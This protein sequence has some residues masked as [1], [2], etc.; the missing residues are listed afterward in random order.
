MSKQPSTR[1]AS[2]TLRLLVAGAV[3]CALGSL[4]TADAQAKGSAKLDRTMQPLVSEYLAIQKTLAK[5]S[6]RDVTKHA[7]RIATLATKL[8]TSSI[9][10]PR[11]KHYQRIPKEIVSAA[12]ELA[13]QKSLTDKRQS[14]K[15][16]S[17]AMA[18]WATLSKPNNLSVVYCSMAKAS[19]VQ[20]GKQIANPYY[21][22]QM[23]R[24]GQIVA[25]AHRATPAA[26]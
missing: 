17:R 8:D 3:L 15:A 5:D 20:R 4:D 6:G 9:S 13:R 22:S 18:L 10:G 23:L 26:T 12:K 1:Y 7:A 14:F 2:R 11:Q 21:G 24:C 16:L 25:G 19:W